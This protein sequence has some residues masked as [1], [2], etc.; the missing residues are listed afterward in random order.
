[1]FGLIYRAHAALTGQ[2]EELIATADDLSGRQVGKSHG[3][4][5]GNCRARV[6]HGALFDIF[7]FPWQ[8]WLWQSECLDLHDFAFVVLDTCSACL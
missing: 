8:D 2:G 1:M 4:S 5:C 6:E 7:S 3:I